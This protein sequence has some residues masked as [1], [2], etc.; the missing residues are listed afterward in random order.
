M[1]LS[2]VKRDLEYQILHSREKIKVLEQKVSIM[3]PAMLTEV[4]QAGY[5]L[6]GLLMSNEDQRSDAGMCASDNLDDAGV[7]ASDKMALNLGRYDVLEQSWI[8]EMESNHLRSKILTRNM[9]DA[10]SKQV[11][12]VQMVIG[13]LMVGVRHQIKYFSLL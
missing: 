10:L 9:A 4:K 5:R 3:L 6:H 7:S 2:D 1:I 11:M 13:V 12:C 8:T